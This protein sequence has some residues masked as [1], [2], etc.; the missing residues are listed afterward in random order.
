MKNTVWTE[1]VVG[2]VRALAEV[3]E[4]AEVT[5]EREALDVVDGVDAAAVEDEDA[6]GA[7]SN[8]NWWVSRPPRL[9]ECWQC[10]SG[11]THAV[12]L[13]GNES[14]RYVFVRFSRVLRLDEVGIK[15]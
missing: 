1:G 8:Q 5:W 15:L 12:S 14:R 3:F 2:K 10:H 9:D 6:E 11:K 13:P 4:L 7:L